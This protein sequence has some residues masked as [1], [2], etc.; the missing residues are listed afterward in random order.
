MADVT[1]GSLLPLAHIY[2]TPSP[3]QKPRGKVG[4]VQRRSAHLLNLLL[5]GGAWLAPSVELTTL[6]V[7][8]S[9][10]TLGRWA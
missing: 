8:S 1:P 3:R 4:R 5:S 9:S 7:E 6:A 2:Q 10:P